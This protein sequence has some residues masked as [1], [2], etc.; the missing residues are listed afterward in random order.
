MLTSDRSTKMMTGCE[1]DER[2]SGSLQGL[3]DRVTEWMSPSALA[4]VDHDGTG[5]SRLHT[6][7]DITGVSD[8][9]GRTETKGPL[10]PPSVPCTI[11]VVLKH[12]FES[13]QCTI[14]HMMGYMVYTS[15]EPN[16][17]KKRVSEFPR[18]GHVWRKADLYARERTP[19]CF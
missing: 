1:R 16:R 13:S 4:S 17:K 15:P 19:L 2:P 12:P 6:T 8:S 7:S 18:R 5:L 14:V 10:G 9:L 11:G 3:A